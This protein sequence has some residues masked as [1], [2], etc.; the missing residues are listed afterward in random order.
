MTVSFDK[1]REKW[2]YSFYHALKRY[3]GYAIDP[4]TK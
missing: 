1:D 3:S 2:R 4:E